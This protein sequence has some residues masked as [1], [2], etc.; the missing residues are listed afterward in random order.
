M[1]L[2]PRPRSRINTEK[3]KRPFPSWIID[4]CPNR[5]RTIDW[6]MLDVGGALRSVEDEDSFRD[7]VDEVGPV[8]VPK[9]DDGAKDSEAGDLAGKTTIN[10]NVSVMQASRSNQIGN[11][12]RKSS[13][14][15]SPNSP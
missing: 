4:P 14:T 7:W 2:E 1:V 11:F 9:A 6:A 13:L 8:V 3:M 12:L 10:H 5:V 15:D